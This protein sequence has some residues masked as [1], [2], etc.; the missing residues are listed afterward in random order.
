MSSN[1]YIFKHKCAILLPLLPISK[2]LRT[3]FICVINIK[4]KKV[5]QESENK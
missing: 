4:R 5:I 1:V 3:D 2:L